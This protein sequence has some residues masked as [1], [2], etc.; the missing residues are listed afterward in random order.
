MKKLICTILTCM[1][2][3]VSVAAQNTTAKIDTNYEMPEGPSS[4]SFVFDSFELKGQN[5]TKVCVINYTTYRSVSFEIFVHSAIT[6]QWESLGKANL[7]AFADRTEIGQKYKNLSKMRYFAIVPAEKDAGN[8]YLFNPAKK[9]TRLVK[10]PLFIEIRKPDDDLNMTP[11]PVFNEPHSYV[12]AESEIPDDSD[13]N[14]SLINMT[15]I[16]TISM[17]VFGYSKK[18]LKW[19]PL[20]TVAATAGKKGKGVL[21]M[22]QYDINEFY[23][24]G[25]SVNGKKDYAFAFM[26]KNDDICVMLMDMAE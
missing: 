3:A 18:D 11:K 24:F 16:P 5:P 13:E 20:G 12:L 14:I 15:S 19:I 26:N 9:Q 4:N 8:E 25:F 22:E 21:E 10:A 6:K 7:R 17:R 23:Y 1:A 2:F